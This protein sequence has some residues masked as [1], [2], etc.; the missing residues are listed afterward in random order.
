MKK[1]K[2]WML[3]AILVICGTSVLSS[4]G[5]D[6]DNPAV[7]RPAKEYFTLWNQCEALTTLQDYVKD[8]TNPTSPNF[9]KEEDR[10]ATFS[11][12]PALVL[13]SSPQNNTELRYTSAPTVKTSQSNQQ[14]G[15]IYA[16]D[17]QVPVALNVD[18]VQQAVDTV[19]GKDLH[20]LLDCSDGS[21]YLIYALPNTAQPSVDDTRSASPSA[22][23]KVALKSCSHLIPVSA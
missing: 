11:G 15:V 14:A 10:I 6:D 19:L 21:Q 23:L 1:T 3:A 9:I 20:L 4:C 12:T 5:N 13:A 17:V 2:F 18:A 16:F 22:T 8:V 7:V